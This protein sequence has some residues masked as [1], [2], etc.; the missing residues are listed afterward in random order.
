MF[1]QLKRGIRLYGLITVGVIGSL[2]AF[3]S[4]AQARDL[5]CWTF[6]FVPGERVRQDT[7]GQVQAGRYWFSDLFAPTVNEQVAANE[8]KR[9]V[10]QH[11]TPLSKTSSYIARCQ[12]VRF[13][14]DDI[15]RVGLALRFGGEGRG[16]PTEHLS[17]SPSPAF[18]E[19]SRTK[20]F[21]TVFQ[22]FAATVTT[23]RYGT[24]F[25]LPHRIARTQV[26]PVTIDLRYIEPD[27]Q[28]KARAAGLLKS[29]CTWEFTLEDLKDE[30]AYYI[31]QY[32]PSST[33]EEFDFTPD[34]AK[35]EAKPSASV[36][37]P[38]IALTVEKAGPTPEETA[39][40]RAKWTM[41][42]V[43][44]DAV[45]RAKAATLQAQSDAKY[46]A[47]LA[48]LHEEMRKRGNA[49]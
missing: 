38:K 34:L 41:E 3:S 6:E 18:I 4:P 8:Y 10:R 5:Y 43:R 36:P 39:A 48:K 14:D 22:C 28:V 26:F 17:W 47:D 40:E 20:T 15:E 1:D 31:D 12:Y 2:V 33:I 25:E 35:R 32:G 27:F 23:S 42:A 37:T 29:R 24:D 45:A 44:A 19:E 30:E 7:Y 11:T 16:R 13:A 46:Q 21:D 49:Q 9:Y